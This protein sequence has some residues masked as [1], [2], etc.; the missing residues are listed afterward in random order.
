MSILHYSILKSIT[1]QVILSKIV[2]HSKQKSRK[3]AAIMSVQ[4]ANG[5]R[6][7]GNNSN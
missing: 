1:E 2:S 3:L 6:F 5:D 7:F 4:P